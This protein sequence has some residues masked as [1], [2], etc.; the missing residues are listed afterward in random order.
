[1]TRKKGVRFAD[2]DYTE[3]DEHALRETMKTNEQK[4]SAGSIIE[5]PCESTVINDEEE[6]VSKGYQPTQENLHQANE[7]A[8][9]TKEHVSVTKEKQ[10]TPPNAKVQSS[11]SK[12]PT[13][14]HSPTGKPPVQSTDTS[15]M[16]RYN[17][18]IFY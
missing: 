8:A 15:K 5:V 7:S 1:M 13:V 12:I 11:K 14:N 16:N 17:A 18:E 3:E 4:T 2:L 10:E 6:H 9:Q